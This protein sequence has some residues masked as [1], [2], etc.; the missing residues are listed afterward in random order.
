MNKPPYLEAGPLSEHQRRRVL[1]EY[2]SM[3]AAARET[4][5]A[6][7]MTMVN[8]YYDLVTDFYEL[9]WGQSFHFAP[10]RKGESFP[11]SLARH[12]A[13]LAEILGL[14][15]GMKVLD[16]GCGVGGPMRTIARF[17]GANVVGIN[18]HKYQVERGRRY[19]Q[20]AGLAGHCSFITADFMSIPVPDNSFDAV[21]AIE[22]TCHAPDKLKLFREIF[23]VMKDGAH[24][25]GYEWCLTPKYDSSNPEHQA[26]KKG[27]EQGAALPD[28]WFQQ[29]VINALSASGFEMIAARDLAGMSHPQRPWWRPLSRPWPISALRRSNSGR[30]IHEQFVQLF[31]AA[32]IA[33]RGSSAA[34]HI[35]NEGAWAMVRGGETGVFTPM[36]L[37]HVRKARGCGDISR[38]ALPSRGRIEMAWNARSQ[39][40]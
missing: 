28:I 32:R 26:I 23:R 14:K 3:H 22:A 4:R 34:F 33:P 17:S 30:W 25:A 9:S 12:E 24:F 39:S 35:L 18:N 2:L 31:E 15:S 6:S 7:Y 19:N 21:Y 36:F 37:F 1:D 38:S 20:A 10:R 5:K 27:I 8:H 29:D 13:Y 11:A 40:H 16:V